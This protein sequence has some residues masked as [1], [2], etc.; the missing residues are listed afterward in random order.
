MNKL[1][2]TTTG[3]LKCGGKPMMAHGGGLD[4]S[5]DYGS[6][7]KPYP[8]VQKN[9]FAGGGRSYP[10]PTKADAVDALRLAGLHGRSD[11]RS[12][13]FRKYPALKKQTGGTLFK[14]QLPIKQEVYDPEMLFKDRYNTEL[15]PEEQVQFDQWVKQASAKRGSDVMMDQGTYDIK[16]WWK[17][18]RTNDVDGH[19]SDRWKKPNHPKFTDESIYSGADGFQ[20]GTWE[21]DAFLPS[22]QT[23]NLYGERGLKRYFNEPNRPEYLNT[24]RFKF[25]INKPSPLKY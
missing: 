16:G 12:K 19:G 15:T 1:L 14:T 6:K 2:K 24:N 4:R 23:M 8:T 10:I 21:G 7:K 22:K 9:D 25:G 18:D 11:V 17:N 5:E 3:I 20:P 13:V